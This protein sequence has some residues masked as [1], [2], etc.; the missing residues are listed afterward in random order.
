MTSIDI[1]HSGRTLEIGDTERQLD[2]EI[3]QT[4]VYTDLVVVLLSFPSQSDVR[5]NVVAFD[6]DGEKRWRIAPIP[7]ADREGAASYVNIRE[8]EGKLIADNW[9][10]ASYEV[11]PETGA[12]EPHRKPRSG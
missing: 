6:M 4:L 1:S 11:D 10:E 8:F 7:T 2:E 9:N 5:D 3:L 12:V